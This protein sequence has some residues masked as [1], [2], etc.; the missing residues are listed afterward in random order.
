MKP[1]GAVIWVGPL[2]VPGKTGC[3]ECLA[4]R[5]RGN[6]EVETSVG[7]QKGMISTFPTSRAILPTSLQMGVNWA[8]TETAKWIV[9]GE[10]Q[11]LE[12]K[13]FTFDITSLS[14][15]QHTLVKR[16]QCG[17]CGVSSPQQKPQ[18][19]ILQSHKNSLQ[20]MVDIAAYLHKKLSKI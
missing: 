16:P 4:K 7:Q 17:V 19:L 3:W 2:F 10:H 6:R 8:A 11:Q 15:E 9:T 13:V 5:L 14:I 1:V 18:P 20:P 12:G